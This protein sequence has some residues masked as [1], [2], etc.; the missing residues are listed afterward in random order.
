MKKGDVVLIPFPF[1]DLT[2]K[3]NRPALI[4]VDS[5][6]DVTVAFITTQL[7]WK[8]NHDIS[9]EPS[10]QNGIKKSSLIRLSKLMTIDKNL[11]IGKLGEISKQEI[12]TVNSQLIKILQL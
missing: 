4:L 1:S 3:K 5:T 7:K 8:E 6:Y 12:I 2:G 9:L 11:V 10:M